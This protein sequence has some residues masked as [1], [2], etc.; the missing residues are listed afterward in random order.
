LVDNGRDDNGI[1]VYLLS[2]VTDF[3]RGVDPQ[4]P[5]VAGDLADL[6]RYASSY[7]I[8]LDTGARRI[9][10][11]S[12]VVLHEQNAEWIVHFFFALAIIQPID[13]QIRARACAKMLGRTPDTSRHPSS[14]I[15][16]THDDMLNLIDAV[17]RPRGQEPS[18]WM[19]SG[20][21]EQIPLMLS[22]CGFFSTGG[23]DGLS[24]ELSFG[25]ETA[26][27]TADGD[28]LHPPVRKWSSFTP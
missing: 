18:Q 22:K 26:L 13:A 2:A 28:R 19:S 24:A 27:I 1:F 16:V 7:A 6:N 10:L 17:Y 14:G 23:K 4:A 5:A 12:S 11:R 8:T 21:F 3:V 9:S 25:N 15:R 20:E